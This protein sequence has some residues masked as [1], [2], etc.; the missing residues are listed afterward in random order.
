MVTDEDASPS[1]GEKL[2]G[3]DEETIVYSVV[4]TEHATLVGSVNARDVSV[5]ALSSSEP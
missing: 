3:K 5:C 2:R 4:M 1:A